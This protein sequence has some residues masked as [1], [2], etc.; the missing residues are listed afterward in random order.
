VSVVQT[1]LNSSGLRSTA[2][3]IKLKLSI[4]PDGIVEENGRPTARCEAEWATYLEASGC[5]YN[6][7][8][9][10]SIMNPFVDG[11]DGATSESYSLSGHCGNA[12]SAP[13][14]ENI[15]EF[16]TS[17]PE[18]RIELLTYSL[19]VIGHSTLC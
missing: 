18:S 16:S 15:V 6:N 19:R 2:V 7:G 17:E 8:R 10:Q 14:P 3:P 11:I 5:A 13:R 4:T 1:R 12:A 9:G